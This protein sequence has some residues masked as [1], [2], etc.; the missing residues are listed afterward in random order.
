MLLLWYENERFVT[1]SDPRR[2]AVSNLD[3]K[4]VIVITFVLIAEEPEE[5][6]RGRSWVD[7]KHVFEGTKIQ[8]GFRPLFFSSCVSS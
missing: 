6:R 8:G 4:V 3:S 7:Q 1:V 2:F 5:D